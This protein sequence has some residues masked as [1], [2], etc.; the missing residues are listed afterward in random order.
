[1]FLSALTTRP[2]PDWA[3]DVRRELSWLFV[4][5]GATL[6][7]STFQKGDFGSRTA[8]VAARNIILRL[9]SDVTLPPGS[10]EARIAPVHIPLDFKPPVLA[11]MAIVLRLHG[12]TP[13]MP[14]YKDFATL[15]GLSNSLRA[16]FT[17]LND[18]YS[19]ENYAT[20]KRNIDE[21]EREHW[22]QWNREHSRPNP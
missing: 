22:Q 6:I 18:A 7:E 1:M 4:E 20:T 17:Q 10:I 2:D 19:Q 9:S 8:V 15:Q 16:K 13:P 3:D 5:Q 14:A 12:K 21:V 11:W